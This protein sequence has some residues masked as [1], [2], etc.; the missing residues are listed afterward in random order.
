MIDR[1]RGRLIEKSPAG[2]VIEVGGVSLAVAIPLSVFERLGEIGGEATLVTFLYVR[3]DVLE[4]YGFGDRDERELFITLI[5]VSG[6][7]PKLAL[8]VLSRFTPDELRIIVADGDVRRLTGVPGVGR[9]TAERLMVE[10]RDR[11]KPTLEPDMEPTTGKPSPIAEAVR[12]LEVLGYSS[13][14]AEKAVRQARR[15]LGAEAPVDELVKQAL[16]GGT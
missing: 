3:E 2:V 7:G 8:A 4:L 11:L 1:V 10:L 9:K 14:D 15:L 12:A 6:V 13:L 5:K 16:R